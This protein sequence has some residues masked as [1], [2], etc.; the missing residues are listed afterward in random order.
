MPAAS[1]AATRKKD[2]ILGISMPWPADVKKKRTEN[3]SMG[4]PKRPL[5]PQF[6]TRSYDLSDVTDAFVRFFN[7]PYPLQTATLKGDQKIARAQRVREPFAKRTNV[8]VVLVSRP[9]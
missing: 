8:R 5:P 6:K 1:K 2:F 7:D 3:R 4:F 9:G